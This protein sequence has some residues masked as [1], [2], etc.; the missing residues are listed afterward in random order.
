MYFIAYLFW[1]SSLNLVCMH[2]RNSLWPPPLF[3]WSNICKG[4]IFV[5]CTCITGKRKSP[6]CKFD[7]NQAMSFEEHDI[8]IPWRLLNT[9]DIIQVLATVSVWSVWKFPS[10]ASLD[11][12]LSNQPTKTIDQV[13]KMNWAHLFSR[14]KNALI[15]YQSKGSF[16]FRRHQIFFFKDSQIE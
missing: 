1:N 3:P 7:Y 14:G 10:T 12:E 5:L 2:T 11:V 4:Y 6:F 16:D 9:H 15:K 8:F 13:Q